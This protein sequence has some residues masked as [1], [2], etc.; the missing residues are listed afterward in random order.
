MALSPRG[1]LIGGL[2]AL[3]VVAAY[4]TAVLVLRY[5]PYTPWRPSTADVPPVRAL[6]GTWVAQDDSTR[7]LVFTREIL[8]QITPDSTVTAPWRM[9]ALPQDATAQP[10]RF[11]V[12]WGREPRIRYTLCTIRY[13]IV[14]VDLEWNGV[15]YRKTRL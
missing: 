5:Q 4:L 15:W 13:G 9:K 8:R 1:R 10:G 11:T 12:E 14:S 3:V 2:I 6:L 7:R